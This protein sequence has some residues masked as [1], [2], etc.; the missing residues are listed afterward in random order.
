MAYHYRRA[1]ASRQAVTI[2]ML[3][4]ILVYRSVTEEQ[5]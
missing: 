4:Q 2:Q 1:R 3:F 5:T